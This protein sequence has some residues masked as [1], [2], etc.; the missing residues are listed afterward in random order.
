MAHCRD[1]LVHR[2][3]EGQRQPM[4]AAALL[5]TLPG[6]AEFV[7][8]AVPPSVDELLTPVAGAAPIAV[9]PVDGVVLVVLPGVLGPA[10]VPDALPAAVPVVFVLATAPVDGAAGAMLDV[11]V[12]PSVDEPSVVDEPVVE[13][14]GAPTP[15]LRF[16]ANA[17]PAQAA[18]APATNSRASEFMG[19]LLRVG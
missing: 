3:S 15:G 8:D 10:S 18:T 16:C 19:V 17:P 5:P 14:H 2:D 13:P 6:A 4:V 12:L 11:P 9:V 7:V 1:R